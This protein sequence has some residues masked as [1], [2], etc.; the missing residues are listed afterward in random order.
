METLHFD[1]H[2]D[3]YDELDVDRRSHVTPFARINHRDEGARL[4]ALAHLLR[5]ARRLAQAGLVS[6]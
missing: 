3:L 5:D 1:V 6:E 4:P 2:P